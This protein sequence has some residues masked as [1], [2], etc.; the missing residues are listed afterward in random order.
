M[1]E[2]SLFATNRRRS[3][4]QRWAA[5]MSFAL[6]AALVTVLVGLPLFFTE[7]LPIAATIIELPPVP[8]SAG[9]PPAERAPSHTPPRGAVS[10]LMNDQLVFVRVPRGKAKIFNDEAPPVPPCVGVC[11]EGSTGNPNGENSLDGI[12]GGPAK[13][14]VIPVPQPT[15]PKQI[16][17]SVMKEGMLLRK[18]TPVYPPIAVITRQQGTVL[19]HAIIGRDGTIQ[20]LQ[21]V[22][23]PPLLIKAAMD[24]VAQWRYRPYVLNGQPVEVDTQITVNFKLGG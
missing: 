17:L 23:G 10:E 14:P 3:P 8:H 5:L 9:P 24:A 11:V 15:A 1:F 7:A 16:R 19:L 4:Q 21:A 22:S 18:V 20:Q 2:D 12:L 13:G 6:Q